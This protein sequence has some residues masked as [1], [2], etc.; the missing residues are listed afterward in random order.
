VWRWL[1]AGLSVYELA[2]LGAPSNKERRALLTTLKGLVADFGLAFG[3]EIVL[4]D[5]SSIRGRNRHAAFA[6]VYFGASDQEDLD[7]AREI[8]QSNSPILP[9]TAPGQNF[10]TVIPDFL[11]DI[12]GH[13]RRNDD[14]EQRELATLLL[15][16]I[17][18][19]RAQRRVFVS[20]RRSEARATA[21]QLHD[22]LSSR[23][24]DVF[25]DTHDIRPGEPFQDV[26][27]NRLCDSDVL[28]MLDTPTYFQSRWT[29]HE[30][31]RAR[32]KEIHILRVVW[33]DHEPNK[34]TEWAETIYLDSADLEQIPLTFKHSRHG[35][36]NSC[37]LSD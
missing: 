10:A 24:F 21:I 6:A 34:Q 8:I 16:C 14:P 18:L 23:I 19:L 31:G 2:I 3:R 7:T 5:G 1:G 36:G 30:L 29:R 35:A 9:T 20:Y 12:N 22:L 11:H 15:E 17:G 25:L 13:E 37:I 28:I 26:L 33:P 4:H 32:A 27:W